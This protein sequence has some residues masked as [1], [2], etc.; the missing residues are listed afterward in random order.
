MN[1]T[2]GSVA[3]ADSTGVSSKPSNVL[4]MRR[5]VRS[6]EEPSAFY[7]FAVETQ[8]ATAPEPIAIDALYVPGTLSKM[9]TALGLLGEMSSI[10][11]EARASSNRMEADRLMQRAQPILPKLFECRSVGDGFGSIVNALHIAFRNLNGKPL[12]AE[13]VNV[14]WRVIRELRKYPAMPL[15]TGVAKIE[16]LEESGLPVDPPE[17]AALLEAIEPT[18]DD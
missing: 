4:E 6:D 17:L 16:E 7:G 11:N 5:P 8:G 3:R 2:S 1:E 10:L 15:E 18:V 14:I 13:Q 12:T 9:V